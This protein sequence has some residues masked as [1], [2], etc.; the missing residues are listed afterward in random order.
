MLDE[1]FEWDDAKAASNLRKHKVAFEVVR[2]V[3]DDIFADDIGPHFVDGEE[4]FKRVG[5]AGGRVFV[6][7]YTERVYDDE[8]MRIRMIS[9]WKANSDE[10]ARYLNQR[11]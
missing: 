1:R 10:Q 11:R 6:V 5:M 9:A 3:F 2:E 4:R 8:L 7:V